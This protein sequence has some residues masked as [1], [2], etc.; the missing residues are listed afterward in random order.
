MEPSSPQM[1]GLPRELQVES[2]HGAWLL[3]FVGVANVMGANDVRC[4]CGGSV[5]VSVME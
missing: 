1:G 3:V 2:P 5:D 4:C